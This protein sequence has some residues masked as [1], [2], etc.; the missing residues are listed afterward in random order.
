MPTH[1]TVHARHLADK[2]AVRQDRSN[3]GGCQRR[4][5]SGCLVRTDEPSLYRIKWRLL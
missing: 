4:I 3:R 2:K 1:S 5:E